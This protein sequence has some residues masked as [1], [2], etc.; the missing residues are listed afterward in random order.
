MLFRSLLDAAGLDVPE[1]FEG[2]SIMPLV[3]GE[4]VD[5]REEVLIQPISHALVGRAVRTDRWKYAVRAEQGV[6]DGGANPGRFQEAELYD[7]HYDPYELSN[8]AGRK[9]HERVA[10]VM[11]QR[12]L[13]R[14][15]AIGEG[16]PTIDP[17]EPRGSG[18]RT[19]TEAE[20]WQ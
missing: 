3:R 15:E 7:L 11:R 12:L 4:S 9:S 5:W 2:H 18:Q 19:V 13:T 14:M 1:T 8:L 16:R 10:E 6:R 20:A 17:P